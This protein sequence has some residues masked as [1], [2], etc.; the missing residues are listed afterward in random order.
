MYVKV[1]VCGFMDQISKGK[2]LKEKKKK[3][4]KH[5]SERVYDPDGYRKRVDCVL[6]KNLDKTEVILKSPFNK[7][8]CMHT[9]ELVRTSKLCQ[10]VIYYTTTIVIARVNRCH[11]NIFSG[12]ASL[13]S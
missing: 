11:I 2:L 6:F 10:K 13:Q 3:S 5:Q 4:K 12:Y 1:S 8:P 9:Q 7:I